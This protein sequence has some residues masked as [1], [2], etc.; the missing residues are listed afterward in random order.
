MGCCG[1]AMSEKLKVRVFTDTGVVNHEVMAYQGE[2]CSRGKWYLD[3]PGTFYLNGC[4]S[5]YGI[6]AEVPKG[7]RK[8][9]GAHWLPMKIPAQTWDSEDKVTVVL[10]HILLT[11]KEVDDE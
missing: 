5:L 7:L 3:G 10:P 2:G 1:A 4:K 11:I 8:F 9:V 6:E